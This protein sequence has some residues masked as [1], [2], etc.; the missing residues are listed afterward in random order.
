MEFL[1]NESSRERD[2]VAISKSNFDA[3][4]KRASESRGVQCVGCEAIAQGGYNTVFR[5]TFEDGQEF[6]AR[7]SGSRSGHNDGVPDEI[8]AYHMKSDVCP[9]GAACFH[10][11]NISTGSHCDTSKP[12]PLFLFHP[13]IQPNLTRTTVLERVSC[14]WTGY[15]R[16]I[17]SPGTFMY[18]PHPEDHK[19]VVCR[20]SEFQAELLKLEFPGIGSLL[21]EQGTVG[22]LSRPCIRPPL[23][24][25]DQ[26]L[27][28]M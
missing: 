1:H 17:F 23:L 16:P 11:L 5:L 21:D 3:L 26:N 27:S 14:S 25:F 22:P 15:G 18:T 20:L 19:K 24:S 4:Q 6:I 10:E 12:I 8:I 7:L 28:N 2:Y 13:S 9:S